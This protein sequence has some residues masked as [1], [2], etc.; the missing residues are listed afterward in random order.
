MKDTAQAA[1]QNAANDKFQE[2][3]AIQWNSYRSDVI[4]KGASKTQIEECYK[5][6]IAG[7]STQAAIMAIATSSSL[8]TMQGLAKEIYDGSPNVTKRAHGEAV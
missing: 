2:M 8:E 1:G 3:V 5:A 6:F 4:P 7:A